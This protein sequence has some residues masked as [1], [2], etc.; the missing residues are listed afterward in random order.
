MDEIINRLSKAV[1][2]LNHIDTAGKQNLL[3]LGGAIDLIEDVIKSLC[4]GSP[5]QE[6]E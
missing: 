2:V 1:F 4:E 3:N 6:A 5:A